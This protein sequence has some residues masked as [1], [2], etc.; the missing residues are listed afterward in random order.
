MNFTV[1]LD[2]AAWERAIIQAAAALGRDF[3]DVLQE[4]ADLLMRDIIRKTPP[5]TKSQGLRRVENDIKF[6]VVAVH[7][8]FLAMLANR[9]GTGPYSGT[10]NLGKG[11]VVPLEYAK[12]LTTVNQVRAWHES[13][14]HRVTGRTKKLSSGQSLDNPRKAFAP[15]TVVADYIRQVKRNVGAAK[16]GWASAQLAVSRG[17]ALP[18]WITDKRRQGSHVKSFAPKMS[19]R[20]TFIAINSSPWAKRPGEGPRIVKA[21]LANRVRQIPVKLERQLKLRYSAAGFLVRGSNILTGTVT[22]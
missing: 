17:R 12:I 8:K 3:P 19:H 1:Q 20:Q 21:S 11:R 18:S 9:F 2:T 6:T 13:K 16:G 4:E 15:K 14:R 5:K 22:S 7:A 10:I